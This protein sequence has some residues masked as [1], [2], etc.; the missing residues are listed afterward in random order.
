M[1]PAGCGLVGGLFLLAG[2]LLGPLAPGAWAAPLP[3]DLEP[4]YSPT[5]RLRRDR[6]EAAR[7]AV[8]A[9]ARERR[10]VP[11]RVGW[12][13]YRAIFHAHAE[14][15]SHT[16]G[17]RPEMLAQARLAGVHAIFL[18]DHYRPP[19][20]FMASWRFLT[21]GVLFIPG[22]ECRGFLAHPAGSVMAWMDRPV[23]EFVAEVG[24]DEGMIFLSHLEE[25]PDHS[26]DGLTGL[27]IY[28]RHFDAKQDLAGLISLAS[29]LTDVRELAE[30][31]DLVRRYPSAVLAAQVRYP[32]SYLA[33]WEAGLREGR[34]LTGVA[35]N[36]CH[37]N[38]VFIVKVVDAD[39]VRLG[40]IVDKDE[41][42]RLITA[43]VRPS[44]RRLTAGRQPGDIVARVDFDPYLQAF[45]CVSTHVL[46]PGLSEPALRRS[47]RGGR[48]YVAHEWMGDATGFRLEARR[49]GVWLGLMGDEVE[50]GSGIELAVVSPLPAR[51]RLVRADGWSAEA[52]GR[53]AVWPVR[54]PGAYR[55]EAWLEI[56]GEWRPW[57]YANPVYV[58]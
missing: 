38:Q 10:E 58:R 37:H 23:P 8:E 22:S 17:T 33:K 45:R 28:N 49:G 57:V 53:E 30:L 7:A 43:A 46:A 2:L 16:G 31:E 35:A 44:I 51:F 11:E 27:E 42:L 1:R 32:E 20:D 48:V 5:E 41:D 36:D 21:N 6:L 56:G 3:A 12:R 24:Q 55:A 19:R 25:R 13:D 54:E 9:L 34:R 52:R 4:R 47:V 15:A 29:R 26:L 18:S 40:T 39:S 50:A 14:D